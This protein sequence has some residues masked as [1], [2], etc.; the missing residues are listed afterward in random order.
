M[1]L[2]RGLEMKLQ[3]DG[4]RLW[5]TLME[6][7]QV[8]REGDGVNRLALNDANK[9]GRDLFTGWLRQEGLEIRVDCIGNI[10][11]FRKGTDRNEPPIVVGSHL[12]TVKEAGVF[13]G[14]LGVLSGLEI[15]RLLNQED[16]ETKRA[17][18][19]AAFTNEE[20]ARF[21]PDMMGS[22]VFTGQLDVETAWAASD[23]DGVTVKDELRR[24]G[25]L[26][27]DELEAGYYLELHIEQGPVLHREGVKVGVVEGVQGMAWW[28]GEYTGEANHAGTTPLHLRR[29]ALLAAAELCLRLRE[30]A[31]KLGE[32]SVATIG[33]LH[34]RPDIRNVVPGGAFFTV[35]FRQYERGLY[36][37]GQE[38]VSSLIRGVAKRHDLD[39]SL[40]QTV[41]AKPVRFDP[42]MVDLVES[43]TKELGLSYRV[44]HSGAG[45][46]AQFMSHICPTAMVFVPSIGGRS[47]CP[48][49]RTLRADCVNGA[50]VLLRCVLEISTGFSRSSQ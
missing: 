41:D 8:G 20:G 38:I 23:D 16:I 39:V 12:D 5:G 45:H 35:D 30:T 25:Y 18:A 22:M 13:D 34:P 19:V 49:E 48:E 6:M 11:G 15:V 27:H 4:N 29:D 9:E 32:G 26:G 10:F 33:R 28:D 40:T 3:I 1:L 31:V 36:E 17:I 7:G 46:D 24:I 42:G 2:T 21:Q 47:H 50:N 14:A 43:K 44:M 37:E